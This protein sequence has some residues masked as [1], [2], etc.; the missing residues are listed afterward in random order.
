MLIYIANCTKQNLRHCFRLP[1]TGRNQMVSIPSGQQVKLGDGWTQSQINH[2]VKHMESFGFRNAK[3][4]NGKIKNFDGVLY[5]I[6]KPVR[7]EQIV[8]GH[9]QLVEHQEMRSAQEA[10]R[11]ALAF[12]AAT[13]DKRSR[14][15]LAKVTEVSVTQ[16][17]PPNAKPTGNEVN[18]S[19]SVTPEVKDNDRIPV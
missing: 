8:D 19:L 11:S 15:R 9:D 6:D 10:T 7:E 1:E 16:D 17:V 13:T 3:D 4:V 12:D 18:F 5:S 14:R 2:I